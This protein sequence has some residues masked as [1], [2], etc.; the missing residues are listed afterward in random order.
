MPFTCFNWIVKGS[1]GAGQLLE[2]FIILSFEY[3]YVQHDQT[4]CYSPK[5]FCLDRHFAGQPAGRLSQFT[6]PT[7]SPVLTGRTSAEHTWLKVEQG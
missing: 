6:A 1:L 3:V 7:T 4:G 2:G 5:K